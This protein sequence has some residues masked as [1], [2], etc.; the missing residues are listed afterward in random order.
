MASGIK[1]IAKGKP[2]LASFAPRLVLLIMWIVGPR[3]NAAFDTLIVPLLYLIF[4]P[5]ATI[6]YVL[7]WNPATGVYGWDWGLGPL[8]RGARQHEVDPT[9]QQTR[10]DTG[11]PVGIRAYPADRL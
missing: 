8:W 1:K 2:I 9:R 3:V 4:L 10:R 7:V 5:Y 6:M 11:L